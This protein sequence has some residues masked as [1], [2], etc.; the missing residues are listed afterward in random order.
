MSTES[1]TFSIVITPSPPISLETSKDFLFLW[2]TKGVTF[3]MSKQLIM[4]AGHWLDLY[5]WYTKT[6]PQH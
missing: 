2:W 1:C 4:H 6:L 5:T 3:E